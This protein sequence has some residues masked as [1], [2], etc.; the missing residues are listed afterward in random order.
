[1]VWTVERIDKLKK[2]WSEGLSASQIAVQLGGVTRNAVIGKLHR[3]FLSNRVKVNENK[4]SDGNRKNVTLGS[5]SPKTRQSS[6]VYICE[7]VLKGQLPVVRSKRKSKS[8][9]KNNTISSGIVLPISRCLRLMELTDNTCKWPLGDPF[10]KDFSFC[11]SD[12]CNDSPYCDYHK[13]L[14]YQ[15]VNDRRKV[16][17]NSE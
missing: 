6:N 8:M 12:V 5:T 17:A 4:Q 13:K 16:Q 14:A 15:R 3:L 7:P 1:M 2:F 11:G 9:E 10:G